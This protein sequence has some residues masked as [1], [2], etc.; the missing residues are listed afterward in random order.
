MEEKNE[1]LVRKLLTQMG[2]LGFLGVDIPEKY[3]GSELTKT[4][5]CILAEGIS[6]GGNGSFGTVWNV[7]T[8]IGA[9]GI[10]LVFGGVIGSI[11]TGILLDKKKLTLGHLDKNCQK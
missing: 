6:K 1:T 10:I 3:G 11:I 5:M 8:S 4:G 7:Q 2:E 9:L